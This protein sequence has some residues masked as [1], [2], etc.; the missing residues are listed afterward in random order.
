LIYRKASEESNQRLL[1]IINM[2][3]ACAANKIKRGM[4]P[5]RITSRLFV[6]ATIA[7][8]AMMVFTNLETKD[9]DA[10]LEAA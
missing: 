3:N 5:M 2:M 6:T 8:F 10:Y 7:V 9:V 4:L 1:E